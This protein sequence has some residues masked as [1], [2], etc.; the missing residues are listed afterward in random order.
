MLHWIVL[1]FYLLPHRKSVVI[2]LL[3]EG[4]FVFLQAM[5]LKATRLI[6]LLDNN[7]SW[8]LWQ[9]V[10]VSC[11]KKVLMESGACIMGQNQSKVALDF[12][13]QNVLTFPVAPSSSKFNPK[14]HRKDINFQWLFLEFLGFW[15][16][17]PKNTRKSYRKLTSFWW[18]FKLNFEDEGAKYITF[19]FLAHHCTMVELS[20]IPQFLIIYQ[21]L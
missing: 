13:N 4:N 15:A 9:S 10:V 8:V 16:Q 3:C 18:L 12:T 2:L 14:R 1:N 6:C 20:T 21:P 17:K 11:A 5:T 19:L 7:Y